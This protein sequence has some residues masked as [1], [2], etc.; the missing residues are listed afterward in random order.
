MLELFLTN[1]PSLIS[2][3]TVIP[4]FV[5]HEIIF[6][7]NCLRAPRAK[8][9]PRTVSVWKQAN[10]AA[11]KEDTKTFTA[12]LLNTDDEDL[13]VQLMWKLIHE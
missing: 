10:V 4:G 9:A 13:S 6:T 11:S 5:D 3:T 2:W 7:D 12:Y 1:W 8:P